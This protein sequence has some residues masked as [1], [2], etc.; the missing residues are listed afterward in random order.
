MSA[1]VWLKDLVEDLQSIFLLKT[2]HFLNVFEE[3]LDNLSCETVALVQDVIRRARDT[4]DDFWHGVFLM[5]YN[6]QA[7][8]AASLEGGVFLI[9]AQANALTKMDATSLLRS[10]VKADDLPN[11]LCQLYSEYLN[12]ALCSCLQ[13][14]QKHGDLLT[15]LHR[16][17]GSEAEEQNEVGVVARAVH[18]R[19]N[20]A[21]KS[22]FKELFETAVEFIVQLEEQMKSESQAGTMVERIQ[23]S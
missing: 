2:A 20:L 12:R 19:I 4:S 22:G 5:D 18:D 3:V 23:H 15:L 14:W 11:L 8:A 6:V 16:T 1:G 10:N 7:T 17:L 13:R 21:W 9:L